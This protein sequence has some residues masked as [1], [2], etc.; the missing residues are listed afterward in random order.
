MKR[1]KQFSFLEIQLHSF[2]AILIGQKKKSKAIGKNSDCKSIR[3]KIINE[4]KN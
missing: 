3:N 1:Q 4:K 2:T